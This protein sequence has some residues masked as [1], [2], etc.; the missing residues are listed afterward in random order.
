[1]NVRIGVKMTTIKKECPYCHL[2]IDVD[3]NDPQSV[4]PF[5]GEALSYTTEEKKYFQLAKSSVFMGEIMQPASNNN[6]LNISTI[7]LNNN[8]RNYNRTILWILSLIIV[9]LCVYFIPKILQTGVKTDTVYESTNANNSPSQKVVQITAPATAD[10]YKGRKYPEVVMD[11]N[12]AGFTNVHP[13]PLYDKHINIF[14]VDIDEV[15]SITI[16]G[17]IDYDTTTLYPSDV[18]VKISYHCWAKDKK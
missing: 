2:V 13:Y 12:N 10:K 18:Y 3:L 5:C 7:R 6:V 16:G 14:A 1:M 9:G 4:C 8:R 15:E 11:F 17:N